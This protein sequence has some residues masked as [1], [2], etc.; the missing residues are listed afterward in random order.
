[1][2]LNGINNRGVINDGLAVS[3]V[4]LKSERIDP[5]KCASE[6]D[7]GMLSSGVYFILSFS[8]A[9][10]VKTLDAVGFSNRLSRSVCFTF[11]LL[12]LCHVLNAQAEPIR[13][14][15]WEATLE[16]G[17]PFYLLGSLHYANRNCY[18]LPVEVERA[19][20]DSTVLAV[21]LDLT[22]PEAEDVAEW[23]GRYRGSHDLSNDVPAP[24]IEQVKQ[25]ARDKSW[26][27]E[28]ISKSRPWVVAAMITSEDFV[29][30]GYSRDFGMDLY[31][32]RAAK[33]DRKRVYELESLRGQFDLFNGLTTADQTFLLL[34]SIEAV[35][36]G[37]NIA[38]LDRMINAW[39]RGDAS[40]FRQLTEEALTKA[41]TPLELG[42]SMYGVRNERMVQRIEALVRSGQRPFVVVGASHVAG[43]DSIVDKLR[44]RGFDIRQVGAEPIPPGELR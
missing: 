1:L 8:G 31:F 18:P 39:L 36:S 11:L 30:H 24:L 34:E 17:G 20:A 33:R 41:P 7:K 27:I 16:S 44:E 38:T 21:E 23:L 25:V 6:R 12:A 4:S 10:A 35:R 26:D 22:R 14:F 5:Q 9:E 40:T 2:A 3:D 37:D 32:I 42:H 43:P 15:M 28:R 29:S 13:I 19:Y